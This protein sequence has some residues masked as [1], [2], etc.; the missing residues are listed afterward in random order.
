MTL[1]K[2]V[3]IGNICNDNDD[4]GI[5]EEG[6]SDYNTFLGDS[7]FS[8]GIGGIKTIGA[9]TKVNCCWNGTDWIA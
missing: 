6:T 3:F 7:C 1:K 8:N 4:W 9:N 5:S 2:S